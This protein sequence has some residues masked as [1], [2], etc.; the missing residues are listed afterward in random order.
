MS[1]RDG[2]RLAW[3]MEPGAPIAAESVTVPED[4]GGPLAREAEVRPQR[5]RNWLN[6][7][8]Q[9]AADGLGGPMEVIIHWE[10]SIGLEFSKNTSQFLLDS[11]HGVE[12]ISSI[13]IEFFAA[14]LP[15]RTKEKVISENR[16]LRF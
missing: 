10:Q 9:T 15:I 1:S 6:F 7:I 4:S 13:H 16:I 8:D 5:R 14:E 12:E 11:I 2:Y 3:N